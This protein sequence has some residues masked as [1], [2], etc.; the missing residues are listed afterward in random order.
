MKPEPLAGR[1]PA[2]LGAVLI[3]HLLVVVATK[4]M[5]GTP[6]DVLWMSHVA[7]G[8]TGAALLVR[9]ALLIAAVA[10]CVLVPH[11]LWLADWLVGRFTGA[12]PLGLTTYLDNADTLT[13]IGTV[14]HFYLVP[15]LLLLVQRVTVDGRRAVATACG[16]FLLL[17]IVSRV[18]LPPESNVNNAYAALPTVTW[19]MFRAMDGM[20]T[21]AYLATLNAIAA[22]IMFI[23]GVLIIGWVSRTAQARST[24]QTRRGR[25]P[26]PPPR[27]P[28]TPDTTYASP[29]S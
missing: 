4:M 25:S 28:G 23:P 12:H 13:W 14:H 1:W 10:T 16:L 2:L 17:S 24:D 6:E 21:V 18:A 3:A 15:L 26:S 29:T 19:P 11:T 20:G 9:S 27:S 5:R 22:G 8:L 7:L